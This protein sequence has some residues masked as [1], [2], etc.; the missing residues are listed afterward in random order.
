MEKRFG[1][2]FVVIIVV[3]LIVVFLIGG[4][5]VLFSPSVSVTRSIS[6][7]DSEVSLS[8]QIVSDQKIIAITEILPEGSEVLD[9]GI[10]QDYEIFSFKESENTWIIAD[11]NNTINAEIFYVI[12]IA[13]GQEIN[14]V[15]Q[16]QINGTMETFDIVGYSVV[17]EGLLGEG[18]GDC[19]I[20]ILD[21]I[22]VRNHVNELVVPGENDIY[23]LTGDNQINILDM[24]VVRNNL[25]AVC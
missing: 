13:V 3:A 15:Y 19:K 14:G 10:N 2:K 20:N 9:Y 11:S 4:R 12:D 24:I 22:A 17:F 21:M 23:D 7:S 8:L 18:T 25:N 5:E 16:Y 1:L 6:V